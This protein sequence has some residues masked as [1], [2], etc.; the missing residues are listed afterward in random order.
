MADKYYPP[1]HKQSKFHCPHCGV[2]ANQEWYLVALAT[3][4][5]AIS[6]RVHRAAMENA[7]AAECT[8]C[9]Q[10]SFWIDGRMI[11][12]AHSTAEPPHADMP[13]KVKAEFDEARQVVA[14]SPRSAAALLRLAMQ[15]LMPHL[16]EKG[17]NL[18]A[19]I[20][21][22]VKKGLDPQIQKACDIV[23]VTGNESVHPGTMNV[24]DKP[25]IAQALFGL[26]NEIVESQIARPKR[27]SKLYNRI[28]AT[29]RDAIK[30][31]DSKP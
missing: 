6:R 1:T 3:E 19:D 27:I 25:E 24:K 29:K 30:K 11:F 15:R 20:A 12:P 8:H 16:N 14:V 9:E 13:A 23:R 2:Y 4:H 7:T 22:L 31:R 17:K 5:Q 18:D 21:S 10:C 26:I 28:P